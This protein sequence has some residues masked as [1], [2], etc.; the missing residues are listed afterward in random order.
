MGVSARVRPSRSV[1]GGGGLRRAA[2]G[3]LLAGLVPALLAGCSWFSSDTG[4]KPTSVSVF[5]VQPGQCFATP[6]EIKAELSD[7]ASVPCDQPHRQEAYAVVPYSAPAGVDASVYPGESALTSFAQGACAQQFTG[8]VGV[9]YLDSSLF[10]T[11]LLPSARSW[12]QGDDRSVTCFVLSTGA[13]LTRS[14]KGT[15][16]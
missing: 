10:F 16:A 8:Y 14:V 2:A 9:S 5:S 1:P 13:E 12:E 11:Y 7:L 15:K 6:T 3:A 4:P